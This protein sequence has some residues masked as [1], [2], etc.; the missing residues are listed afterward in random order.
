MIDVDLLGLGIEPAEAAPAGIDVEPEDALLIAHQPVGIGRKAVVA[1]DLEQLHRAG[2]AVHPADGDLAVGIV[3]GE[4]EIAVEIHAAVMGDE[5]ELGR[6][7]QG[8]VGPVI[9]LVG[10]S[11]PALGDHGK[12]VELPHHARG[13]AGRTG[14]AA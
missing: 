11:D 6:R 12:I 9:G 13:F 1:V 14:T 2:L 10:G 7:S 4:P 3:R 8:P 5:P